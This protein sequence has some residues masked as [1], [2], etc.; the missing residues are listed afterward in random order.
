[1][2]RPQG[3]RSESGESEGALALLRT[4][5]ESPEYAGLHKHERSAQAKRG[6]P[7]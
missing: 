2:A 6:S 3:Y 1:V 4:S 7:L 5:Q